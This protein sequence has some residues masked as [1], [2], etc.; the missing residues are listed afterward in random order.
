[1]KKILSI[2]LALLLC[3]AVFFGCS[4]SVPG[5]EA[6]TSAETGTMW[7]GAH[8]NENGYVTIQEFNDDMLTYT[9]EM[10]DGTYFNGSAEV[11]GDTAWTD[12]LHFVM[13]GSVVTVSVDESE[14][15]NP[16]YEVFAGEYTW[17]DE[18]AAAE[19]AI[20]EVDGGR[21]AADDGALGEGTYGGAEKGFFTGY[22]YEADLQDCSYCIAIYED[23]TFE[24]RSGGEA[25]VS[26]TYVQSVESDEWTDKDAITLTA[27]DGTELY[28]TYFIDTLDVVTVDG[29]EVSFLPGPDPMADGSYV[30][31][32]GDVSFLV[33]DWYPN[34]DETE[35]VI[36]FHDDYTY[37]WAS[38]MGYMGYNYIFDGACLMIRAG[39]EILRCEMTDENTIWFEQE[40]TSY[41]RAD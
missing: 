21:E 23:G 12:A 28:A 9:F 18:E 19:P 36:S 6:E 27:D 10:N 40:E 25:Q 37:E 4:N 34:G 31:N 30:D 20:G 38:G 13:D 22:W 24:I 11:D 1:M 3:T 16:D 15:G 33:G 2:L 29:D 35:G 26:G 17:T 7:F 14:A 32:T 39:D 5:V 41:Q 8:K